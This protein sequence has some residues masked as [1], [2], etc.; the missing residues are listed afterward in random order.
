MIDSLAPGLTRRIVAAVLL[1]CVALVLPDTVQAQERVTDPALEPLL[2][3]ARE[4]GMSV[5]VI[6]SPQPAPAQVRPMPS[7]GN[8]LAE[9]AGRIVKRVQALAAAAATPGW[10]EPSSEP[11]KPLLN[12][13]L[14]V[15]GVI[16]GLFVLRRAGLE[17]RE[18]SATA[19]PDSTRAVDRPAR[20]AR[21]GLGI[22]VVAVFAMVLP[23]AVNGPGSKTVELVGAIIEIFLRCAVVLLVAVP[24]LERANEGCA[25]SA[26]IVDTERLT[27]D[28]RVALA[29]IFLFA[30][31]A[32]TVSFM[33]PDPVVETLARLE[34]V[35]LVSG[36]AVL[37]A[38]RHRDDLAV[39]ASSVAGGRLRAIAGSAWVLLAGYLAAAWAI[40]CVRILLRIPDAIDL[41]VAPVAALLGGVAVYHVS[42]W[43]FSLLLPH[44]RHNPAQPGSLP[45]VTR[46]ERWPGRLARALG[47]A[48]ALV[49]AFERLGFAMQRADGALAAVPATTIVLLLAYGVWAYF[50]ELID[51][52]VALESGPG[53]VQ[54]G[55]AEGG[56]GRSRLA[57][58]LPIL[59]NAL[60]VAVVFVAGLVLLQEAG[61]NTTPI[62]A[63][64]GIVGLAIGFGAQSL[65]K[66]IIS[67]LFF[68]LDDAFRVGEYI[69]TGGLKGSV[70]RISIRSMQLRHHNGP[71]NTIAFGSIDELT[72]YSR[73]WVIMKLPIVVTLDTDLERVRKMVKKLGTDLLNDP[74]VGHKFLEP[75]KSQGVLSIDNWGMKIRVKFKTRPGD[76][77]TVRRVVYAKLH[78]TFERE[79]IQFASRD[80]KVKIDAPSGGDAAEQQAIAA[81][82]RTLDERAPNE[83]Q[84][85]PVA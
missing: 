31:A 81:A 26:R 65:V 46:P 19:G 16:A 68:L 3:A 80:V 83:A 85:R 56:P 72:N 13:L 79:G 53:P 54:D 10:P 71:L 4:K 47:L 51:R 75:L 49:L 78:E 84:I 35:T 63:S 5:V 39:L 36:L 60:Q 30:S 32:L 69:E 42:L 77:F 27:R 73:D 41:V 17:Y 38:Y 14:T 34:F 45:A 57:T 66:D 59:R 24:L 33:Y 52:R 37:L 21:A 74:M 55:D 11:Q 8:A 62:F 50:S 20:V 6:G 18:R 58:L 12:G 23:F 25:G 40:A 2:E 61:I 44:R 15:I 64:A 48:A 76:Q 7:G 28:L 9:L 29:T 43:I 70:E 82:A 67:G 22:L 1:L